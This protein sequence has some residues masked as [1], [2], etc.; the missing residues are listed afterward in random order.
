ME[1]R[2]VDKPAARKDATGVEEAVA[3]DCS[4]ALRLSGR[5]WLIVAVV[6][7]AFFALAPALCDRIEAFDPDS[8]YRIPYELSSDYWLYRRHC[9]RACDRGK[10]LVVGDSVVWGH[11]V[12]PEQ[13]LTHYLNEIS[14]RDRFANLGLDGTHPAALE[15]LLRHY[16]RLSGR[17][18]LLH[19]NPLWMSSTKH[20]LQTSKEFH[21]NHAEL[22]A[23]FAPKIPCYK[24]S[25]GKRLRIAVRRKVPF[26]NWMNHL[27]SAYY[28]SMDFQTWTL[29]RPCRNPVMPLL[30]GLP[31]SVG[32]PE[33]SGGSW[34]DKGAKKQRLAWV[35]LESSLQWR[36]FR[37]AVELLQS[38]G[39][40]VFV[41]VGP[42]NEHMLNEADAALYDT[43]KNGV[44]TWLHEN[45][46]PS[47]IPSPLPASYYV[48]ASHPVGE[49]YA[50]LAK[51][52][53]SQP[54]FASLVGPTTS[55][56]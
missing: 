45:E 4:H 53:L 9:R 32:V 15:G 5:D 41:L 48:D 6:L 18:V 10:V 7:L 1:D 25:R 29:E 46:V 35:E 38:G 2:Q 51:R 56:D 50:L 33:P 14:G 30:G 55:E 28:G 31:A 23:Q 39:N 19:L 17:V 44:E 8:D 26:S 43:I 11:Y 40:K 52:L 34:V 13:S 21:F 36:F 27:R 22:V 54:Q 3:F 47:F 24:A 12:P 20:D 49:G 16:G 37:R 42:F